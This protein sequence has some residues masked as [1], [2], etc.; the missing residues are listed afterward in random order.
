[1]EAK[2]EQLNQ[3]NEITNEEQKEEWNVNEL[4]SVTQGLEQNRDVENNS[5]GGEEENNSEGGEEENNSERGEEESYSESESDELLKSV[6]PDRGIFVSW[7]LAYDWQGHTEEDKVLWAS[8]CDT[9]KTETFQRCGIIIGLVFRILTVALIF[10]FKSQTSVYR[11]SRDDYGGNRTDLPLVQ[12]TSLFDLKVVDAMGFANNTNDTCDSNWVDYMING[13]RTS[14]KAFILEFSSD[15]TDIKPRLLSCPDTDEFLRVIFPWI[16][17]ITICAWFV[18]KGFLSHLRQ[19]VKGGRL[20]DEQRPSGAI[21]GT[22]FWCIRLSEVAVLAVIDISLQ[23]ILEPLSLLILT[24][25]RQNFS[26]S[27]THF[28]GTFTILL[29]SCILVLLGLCIAVVVL[30]TL[31][32]ILEKVLGMMS[33]EC[34]CTIARGKIVPVI[35]YYGTLVGLFVFGALVQ[36]KL[37]VRVVGIYNECVQDNMISQACED[38]AETGQRIF[39]TFITG[40]FTIP[41]DFWTNEAPDPE[42]KIYA[43]TIANFMAVGAIAPTAII[44]FLTIIGSVIDTV[45]SIYRRFSN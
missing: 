21:V 34:P 37:I 15:T 18:L 6:L 25:V 12:N 28:D 10:G 26:L 4:P 27:L 41:T 39:R 17:I 20:K 5:E 36:I 8:K 23:S 22:I 2:F 13:G 42:P 40:L 3:D 29:L 7:L 43:I 33:W 24:P 14:Q 31:A 32:F 38:R 11:I 9:R 16:I 30:E 45:L 44:S 19:T 35:A 1:M